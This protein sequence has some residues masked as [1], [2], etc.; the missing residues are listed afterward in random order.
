LIRLRE[1]YEAIDDQCNIIDPISTEKYGTFPKFGITLTLLFQKAFNEPIRITLN[2]FLK[3]FGMRYIS[4]SSK[5]DTG[6]L[7]IPT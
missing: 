5:Y 1:E 4:P 7:I 2:P 3:Y 6:E